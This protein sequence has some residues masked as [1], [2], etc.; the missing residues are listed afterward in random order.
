MPESRRRH[1][2]VTNCVSRQ[3]R[4]VSGMAPGAA[5]K[6][7]RTGLAGVGTKN[8]APDEPGLRTMPA[9]RCAAGA[10]HSGQHHGRHSAGRNFDASVPVEQ[11]QAITPVGGVPAT[12]AA[13]LALGSRISVLSA[14]TLVP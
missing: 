1:G 14:S 9:T 4:S 10:S 6:G 3:T 2:K 12:S 7:P 13:P 11:V 8:K 5:T